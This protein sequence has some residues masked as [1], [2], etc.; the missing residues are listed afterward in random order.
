MSGGLGRLDQPQRRDCDTDH[1]NS[2]SCNGNTPKQY[3]YRQRT[4]SNAKNLGHSWSAHQV[5][6]VLLTWCRPQYTQSFPGLSYALVAHRTTT[7]TSPYNTA[8]TQYYRR[9]GT[10]PTQLPGLRQSI[11]LLPRSAKDHINQVKIG[12]PNPCP[13]SASEEGQ[14]GLLG[15]QRRG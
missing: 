6:L 14:P 3:R 15:R 9:P 7:P 8:D 5:E 10:S 1:P 11:R 12:N 2:T 13:A 4:R